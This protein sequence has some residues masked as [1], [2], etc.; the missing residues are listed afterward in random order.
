M[1][2]RHYDGTTKYDKNYPVHRASRHNG[3]VVKFS[4]PS[5]GVVIADP[6]GERL[7]YSTTSWIR[8]TDNVT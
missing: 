3:R 2:N 6:T 1:I 4:S 8:H 7:G 5:T